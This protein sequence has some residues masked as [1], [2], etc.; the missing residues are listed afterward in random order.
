MGFPGTGRGIN[1]LYPKTGVTLGEQ[2]GG[3]LFEWDKKR[4]LESA[5]AE[6]QRLPQDL[7]PGTYTTRV[8]GTLFKHGIRPGPVTQTLLQQHYLGY[9]ARQAQLK[10]ARKLDAQDRQARLVMETLGMLAPPRAGVAGGTELPSRPLVSQRPAGAKVAPAPQITEQPL[11]PGTAGISEIQ[12]RLRAEAGE[13]PSQPGYPHRGSPQGGTEDPAMAAYEAGMA[14]IAMLQAALGDPKAALSTAQKVLENRLK[15]F[16]ETQK[17]AKEKADPLADTVLNRQAKRLA[18]IEERRVPPAVRRL[19]KYQYFLDEGRKPEEAKVL[20]GV[21]DEDFEQ[22]RIYEVL[23]KIMEEARRDPFATYA[24][25][26]RM[27][28]DGRLYID[29]VTGLP[30][31]LKEWP[32]VVGK[33]VG[34]DK[35]RILG[36]FRDDAKELVALLNDPEVRAA[37]GKVFSGEEGW[38]KTLGDIRNKTANWIKLQL[39][40]AGI[41]VSPKVAE[42]IIRIQALASEE[43]HRLLGAAV[44]AMEMES[45]TPHLPAAD[46]SWDVIVDKI[47]WFAHE[48]DQEFLRWLDMYRDVANMAP[49]YKAFDLDPFRPEPVPQVDSRPVNVSTEDLKVY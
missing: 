36:E 31:K 44:T 9:Q 39:H 10:E 49:W 25:G 8:L 17:E 34:V 38:L 43:R 7:D 40:K 13:Q 18:A 46:D 33:R 2:A 12:T 21:T 5:L 30:V 29:P 35:G 42:T 37:M 24:R 6:I 26:Y 27:T 45:V 3:I 48:A 47:N 23:P 22:A 20:A 19:L 15:R 14:R 41:S 1:E 28:R 16:E 32:E 11:K 4:R